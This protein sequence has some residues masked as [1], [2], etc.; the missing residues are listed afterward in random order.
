M[1]FKTKRELYNFLDNFN[2][3]SKKTTKLSSVY[4]LVAFDNNEYPIYFSHFRN[5]WFAAPCELYYFKLPDNELMNY[6]KQMYEKDS[7]K[8]A[9]EYEKIFQRNGIHYEINCPQCAPFLPEEVA[10]LDVFSE[11]ECLD[12]FLE[13]T[14]KE[15]EDDI[16]E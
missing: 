16:D 6:V 3:T 7:I 2:F 1:K 15:K 12:W 14:K 4:F 9:Y 11:E 8:E 10:I 13:N 5:M